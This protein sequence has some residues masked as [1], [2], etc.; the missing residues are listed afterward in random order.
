MKRRPVLKCKY[1]ST[2]AAANSVKKKICKTRQE[3]KKQL[4]RTLTIKKTKNLCNALV[5]DQK[6]I[7][8]ATDRITNNLLNKASVSIYLK[9]KAFVSIYKKLGN[10]KILTSEKTPIT[11]PFVEKKQYV[12][13]S[14]LCSFKGPFE[15]LQADIA[16][17]RFLGKSAADPKYCLLFVNLFTSMIYTY[18]MKTRNL[19]P[20]KMALFYNDIKNKRSGKM[21]LQTDQEF[22]QNNK[23]IKQR[24]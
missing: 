16:D 11:T 15:A 4:K 22:Q 17:I 6:S 13:H 5:E 14:T 7:F 20:R 21:R 10:K 23:K 2:T 12:N 18:S 19:L 24:I 8:Y 1:N 3:E 9:D